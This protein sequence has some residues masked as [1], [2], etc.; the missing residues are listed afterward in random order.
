MPKLI[1]V[2]HSYSVC[3]IAKDLNCTRNLRVRKAKISVRQSKFG[4]IWPNCLVLYF[5]NSW[6]KCQIGWCCMSCRYGERF[7][8]NRSLNSVSFVVA[9][10]VSQDSKSAWQVKS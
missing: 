6:K 9:V 8:V 1:L 4:T 5:R 2:F 7:C 3:G 10:N